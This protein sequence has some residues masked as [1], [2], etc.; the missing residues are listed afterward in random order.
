MEVINMDL[1]QARDQLWLRVK[2]TQ[3]VITVGVGTKNG[4]AVLVIFFDKK[5]VNEK[6]LPIEHANI[7]VIHEPAGNAIAYGG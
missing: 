6:D 7:P 4:K 3:G 1:Y 5:K 2:D